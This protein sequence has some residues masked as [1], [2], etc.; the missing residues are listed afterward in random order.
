MTAAD[1]PRAVLV[2]RASKQPS[3]LLQDGISTTAIVAG[4][5]AI[6]LPVGPLFGVG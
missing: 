5:N 1:L 2:R 3:A 6:G 4:N